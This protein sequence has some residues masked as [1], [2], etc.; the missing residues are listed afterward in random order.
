MIREA[1]KL[2]L[3]EINN[4]LSEFNYKISNLDEEFLNVVVHV[5]NNIDAVLVYKYIYD[6]IEIDYIVVKEDKRRCGLAT[7]LIKYLDKYNCSITLEVNEIN[8][9]AINLY[10]KCGFKEVAKRKNYY[11]ENDAILMMKSGD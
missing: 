1:N 7:S 10:K 4:L 5:E 11:K 6:R 2:D 8:K 3:E 9:E